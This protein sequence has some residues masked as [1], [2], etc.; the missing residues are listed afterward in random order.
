M[1]AG[2]SGLGSPCRGN[3]QH[4]YFNHSSVLEAFGMPFDNNL[5]PMS[6]GGENIIYG[7]D[8]GFVGHIYDEAIKAGKRVLIFEGDLDPTGLRTAP[9]EDIFVPHF[10]NGTG[11]WTPV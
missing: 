4:E 10:G 8:R 7:T 1:G 9:I 6:T 5:I 11:T 2:D 3:S